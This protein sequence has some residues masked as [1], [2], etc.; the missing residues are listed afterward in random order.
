MDAQ[1]L[2]SIL[3]QNLP[4]LAYL[5]GSFLF[6][7]IGY[8]AYRHGKKTV[9]KKSKWIGVGL[10]FYPYLIGSD[11]RLLWLVGMLLCLALYAVRHEV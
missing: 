4:S 8:V 11:T 10:M 9:Q 1:A 5:A 2:L 7:I 6:G 3:L